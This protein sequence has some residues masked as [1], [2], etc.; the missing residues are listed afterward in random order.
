MRRSHLRA[1]AATATPSKCPRCQ[2]A[3]LPHRVCLSCGYYKDVEVIKL[4][5]F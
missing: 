2:E 5:Q 1:K 4:D 3:K